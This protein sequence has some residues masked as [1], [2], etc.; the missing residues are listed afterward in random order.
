M[1]TDAVADT[2]IDELRAS[3]AVPWMLPAMPC[4][5][6]T[7][8]A[9]PSEIVTPAPAPPMVRPR[10]DAPILMMVV[11]STVPS[12]PSGPGAVAF[13]KENTPV[14]VCPKTVTSTG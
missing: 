12:M 11:S 13:S 6:M 8:S 4:G 10:C 14:R 9:D 2:E 1:S 3:E 7:S 5:A